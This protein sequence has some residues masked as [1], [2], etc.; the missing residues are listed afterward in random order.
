MLLSLTFIALVVMYSSLAII[1]AIP[2][3]KAVAAGKVADPVYDTLTT[4]WATEI[5]KPVE[6]LF[7]IGFLRRFLALQTSASRIIWS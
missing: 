2:D 7:V 6:V 1:L 3:L 4:H 5:A